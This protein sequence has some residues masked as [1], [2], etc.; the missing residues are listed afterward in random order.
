LF[1]FGQQELVL[2]QLSPDRWYRMAFMAFHETESNFFQVFGGQRV[3]L[4]ER[5][6][7]KSGPLRNGLRFG[8]WIETFLF[9][10][11]RDTT[12]AWSDLDPTRGR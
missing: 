7:R 2:G 10:S 9:W 11:S 5:C 1:L 8:S 6:F 3:K 4:V 12:L